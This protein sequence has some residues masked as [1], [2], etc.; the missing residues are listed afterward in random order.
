MAEL[1]L[2]GRHALITGGSSGIGLATAR[3]LVRAGAAVTVFDIAPPP[4]DL[5]YHLG[6]VSRGEDIDRAWAKLNAANDLPDILIANA[7]VGLYERLCEGDP[8]KWQRL[9]DIDV[10][11]ALRLVRAFVPPLLEG[12]GDVVFVSSVA[13]GRAHPWGGPYAASKAALES[14]AETLRLEAQPRVRVITVAPGV[15]D[16]P[17]FDHLLAGE[18]SIAAMGAGS[19]SPEH[20][21]ELIVYALSRPTKLALNHITVRPRTQEF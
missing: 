11:G 18:Q 5:N 9:F 13:A 20:V 8:E 2:G 7:G 14:I 21:A 17:F 19:I 3:A 1:G 12:G 6:D 10:M 15:V 4:P 16:T